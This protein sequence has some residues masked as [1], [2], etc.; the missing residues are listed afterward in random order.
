MLRLVICLATIMLVFVT[1]ATS[2]QHQRSH[3]HG[4]RLNSIVDTSK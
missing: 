3:R 4:R 1:A 2:H